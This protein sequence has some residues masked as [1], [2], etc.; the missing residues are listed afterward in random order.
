MLREKCW[1]RGRVVLKFQMSEITKIK[2]AVV[3]PLCG[4]VRQVAFD[5]I[6]IA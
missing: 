6:A 5:D 4:Y 2:Q 1:S 3:K